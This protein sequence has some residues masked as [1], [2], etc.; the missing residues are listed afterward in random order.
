M[1]IDLLGP[2]YE[3]AG[4]TLDCKDVRASI[5]SAIGSTTSRDGP[6][7]NGHT[8]H[9]FYDVRDD[10][11]ASSRVD[12][13]EETISYLSIWFSR[14]KRRLASHAFRARE[15]GWDRRLLFCKRFSSSC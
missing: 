14:M 15:G 2:V 6:R 4:D 12:R 13:A 7:K 8:T 5:C 10:G 9:R 1:R 11:G 3:V